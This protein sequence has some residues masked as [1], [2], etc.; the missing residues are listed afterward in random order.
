MLGA[1]S[2]PL[3][4]RNLPLPEKLIFF[5]VCASKSWCY[6]DPEDDE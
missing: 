4:V 1:S 2:E 6:L 5:R 3:S